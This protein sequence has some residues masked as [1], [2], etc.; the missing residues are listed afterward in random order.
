MGQKLEAYKQAVEDKARQ[1]GERL[2]L[3]NTEIDD[4][5]DELDVHYETNSRAGGFATVAPPRARSG[6]GMLGGRRSPQFAIELS[7]TVDVRVEFTDRATRELGNGYP[8]DL[9]RLSEGLNRLMRANISADATPEQII[10]TAE[11]M[12]YVRVIEQ[13]TR[14]SW[15]VTDIA[16]W[17]D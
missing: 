3:S 6:Q 11:Q 17:D 14:G 2:G 1:A 5:L 15:E 13:D 12:G 16:R 7:K 10:R 4:F 8:D 9:G